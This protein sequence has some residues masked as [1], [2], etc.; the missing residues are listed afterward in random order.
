[1]SEGRLCAV[2]NWCRRTS[3]PVNDRGA[4]ITLLP[5]ASARGRNRH[6]ARGPRGLPQRP[7]EAPGLLLGP[8][9]PRT[10]LQVNGVISS[11]GVRTEALCLACKQWFLGGRGCRATRSRISADGSRR[12]SPPA[13]TH[14][15][16]RAGP[17]LP[18]SFFGNVTGFLLVPESVVVFLM[19]WPT[20]RASARYSCLRD[21]EVTP[22][23]HVPGGMPVERFL[24]RCQGRAL[25]PSLR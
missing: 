2:G 4:R 20:P 7:R 19:P 5:S 9:R 25:D 1:M 21:I 22:G 11:L 16:V 17:P 24:P 15:E 18:P 14:H 12:V 10:Q 13:G 23:S 8:H 3:S 6:R